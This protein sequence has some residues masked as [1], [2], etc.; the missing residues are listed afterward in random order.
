MWNGAWWRHL[1]GDELDEFHGFPRGYTGSP[2]LREEDREWLH[3]S[4]MHAEVIHRC[5]ADL[6]NHCLARE[7]ESKNELVNSEYIS[8]LDAAWEAINSSEIFNVPE[9]DLR[10]ETEQPYYRIGD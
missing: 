8:V 2:G 6:E 10:E 3:G 9:K 1:S 7:V 5:F 4:T